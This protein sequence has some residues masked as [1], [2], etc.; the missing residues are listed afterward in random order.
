MRNIEY[1]FKLYYSPLTTP[2]NL[3]ENALLPN[4]EYVKYYTEGDELIAE[5]KCSMDDVDAIFYYHFTDN[6]LQKI[7]MEQSGTKEVKFERSTEIKEVRLELLQNC[8]SNK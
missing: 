4:Y 3:L 7:I 8:S 1:L 5:M 6:N 2:Y